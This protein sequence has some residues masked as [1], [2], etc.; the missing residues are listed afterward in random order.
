M[1]SG[2]QAGL[3]EQG[4]K[5]GAAVGTMKRKKLRRNP[6]RKARLSLKEIQGLVWDT[7]FS[8]FDRP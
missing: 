8:D 7:L 3:A 2:L 4:P 5:Q 1:D 6:V